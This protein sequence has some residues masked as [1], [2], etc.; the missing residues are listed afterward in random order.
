M[1]SLDGASARP[2]K[3]VA[4]S[5]NAVTLSS[6]PLQFSGTLMLFMRARV[7]ERHSFGYFSVAADTKNAGSVFE[8]AMPGPKGESQGWLS[9]K[10]DSPAGEPLR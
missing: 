4:P 6:S 9:Y 10:S 3:R 2:G 7:K 8:Q 1:I 5:Q